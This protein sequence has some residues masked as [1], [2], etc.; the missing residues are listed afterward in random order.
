MKIGIDLRSLQDKTNRGASSYAVPLIEEMTRQASADP[1]IGFVSGRYPAPDL[2][3]PTK[4]IDLPSKITNASL[5]L[6]NYP[7]IDLLLG[8]ETV[9]MPN[10]TFWSFSKTAR[11]I[12][13]VHDLSFMVDPSWYSA[14]DRLWHRIIHAKKLIARA[15]KLLTLS[16]HTAGE[17]NELMHV[18][19][20]KISVIPPGVPPVLS[21]NDKTLG[22]PYILFIGVIEPRKNIETALAAF[23]LLAKKNKDI[24]FVLAGPRHMNHEPW[25]MDHPERV[26]FLGQVS[27][28]QK[29][30][31]LRNAKALFFPSYYEGFGFPALEAMSVGVPVVASGVGALPE[32]VKNAGILL[33]PRDAG[34]FAEALDQVLNDR[35]LRETLIS[36]GYE[37]V[38]NFSWERCAAETMR[39]IRD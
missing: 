36:R 1:F 21:S 5:S 22:F 19:A 38:K 34:A 28:E 8:T 10:W 26:H 15:D 18:P 14:K 3:F 25:T 9:W 4:K 30:A 17:L 35:A 7:K 11:V 20:E 13:T 6:F 29:G 23:D 37:R 33:D 16:E 27:P 39:A 2:K 32:V 24:H 12:L 31:L